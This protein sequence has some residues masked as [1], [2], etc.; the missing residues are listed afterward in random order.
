MTRPRST[1]HALVTCSIKCLTQ[2]YGPALSRPAV[3]LQQGFVLI[4]VLV[5]LV[6]FTVT[7]GSLAWSVSIRSLGV[8]SRVA[9]N[10][11]CLA[12]TA[13][14]AII[15][16]KLR[17]GELASR[18]C[19]EGFGQGIIRLG[20]VSVYYQVWDEAG[21]YKVKPGSSSVLPDFLAGLGV[22]L[23]TDQGKAKAQW[24]TLLYEDVFEVGL[25]EL[26]K[27]YGPNPE[28]KAVVDKVTLWSDGRLN[29]NT[30]TSEALTV[31]LAGMDPESLER[32]LE[33]RRRRPILDLG[34]VVFSLHLGQ[35][36]AQIVLSRLTTQTNR[37]AV[38]LVCQGKTL[39][40]DAFVVMDLET[41]G[42]EVL[43][44][45]D[46]PAIGRIPDEERRAMMGNNL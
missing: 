16:R 20:S 18:V 14:L 7:T 37:L 38:R 29:V 43:L 13:A 42:P 24:K 17:D 15:D 46:L 28:R 19:S 32:L 25:G 22:K 39:R 11:N 40:S 21:K 34:Q 33:L 4:A 6:V 10:Q 31:H 36:D 45:R 30:A 44:W 9:H 2:A 27:F 41:N 26:A 8:N 5:M 23:R 3:N 35:R 12:M 1:T